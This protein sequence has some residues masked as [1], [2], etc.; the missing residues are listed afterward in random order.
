MVGTVLVVFLQRWRKICTV[1]QPMGNK[2]RYLKKCPKR[3]CPIRSKETRIKYMPLTLLTARNTLFCYYKIIWG[4]KVIRKWSCSLFRTRTNHTYH[5]N[6]NPSREAVP[7]QGKTENKNISRH[8]FFHEFSIACCNKCIVQ[9][10]G[11]PAVLPKPW[12]L[13]STTCPVKTGTEHLDTTARMGA[14]TKGKQRGM[15]LMCIRP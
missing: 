3:C 12:E 7:L 11:S 1:L 2:G 6:P 4:P 14:S 9:E 5:Q 13:T 15:S 10:L 8:L